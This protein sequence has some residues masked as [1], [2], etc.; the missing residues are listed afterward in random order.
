[1]DLLN[2]VNWFQFSNTRNIPQNWEMTPLYFWVY[3]L[4]CKTV[5]IAGLLTLTSAICL[6]EISGFPINPSGNEQEQQGKKNFG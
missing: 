6:Y 4:V 5:S 1:M 3:F 2:D